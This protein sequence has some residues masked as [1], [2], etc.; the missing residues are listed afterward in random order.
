MGGQ[1]RQNAT[2]DRLKRFLETPLAVHGFV[3]GTASVY[4]IAPFLSGNYGNAGPWLVRECVWAV[5]RR[6]IDGA[7]SVDVCYHISPPSCTC[8]RSPC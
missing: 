7:T 1:G 8:T 5:G 3:W 4:M 2:L 6:D